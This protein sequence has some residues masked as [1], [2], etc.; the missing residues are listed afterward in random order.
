MPGVSADR[1][2]GM[3]GGAARNAGR[4]R[5]PN[6]LAACAEMMRLIGRFARYAENRPSRGDRCGF[7]L[8]GGTSGVNGSARLSA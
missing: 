2:V 3:L 8:D 4:A 1:Q 6:T 5:L 7:A